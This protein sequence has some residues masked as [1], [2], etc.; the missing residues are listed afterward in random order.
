MIKIVYEKRREE[1]L[2][3]Y[4]CVA[5]AGEGCLETSITTDIISIFVTFVSSEN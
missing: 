5:A 2:V 3:E 4:N 1:I